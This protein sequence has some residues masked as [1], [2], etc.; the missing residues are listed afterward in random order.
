M[1][2]GGPGHRPPPHRSY[3]A[4][5]R[6]RRCPGRWPARRWR[7][8]LRVRL[9]RSPIARGP[10]PHPGGAVGRGDDGR[11][12]R[13]VLLTLAGRAVRPLPTGRR[14]AARSGAASRRLHLP[15][16]GSGPARGPR[17]A[18][19]VRLGRGLP[20]SLRPVPGGPGPAGP[21]RR[22]S[23]DRPLGRPRVRRRR[24][25]GRG[26]RDRAG[27]VA[28][29]TRCGDRGPPDVAAAAGHRQRPDRRRPVA[30]SRSGRR[31]DRRRLPHGRPGAAAQ[32]R[33]RPGPATTGAETAPDRGAVGVARRLPGR[34]DRVPPAAGHLGP[35]LPPAAAGPALPGMAAAALGGQPRPVGRLP[36]GAAATARSVAPP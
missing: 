32:G 29:A 1:V 3:R 26:P 33:R 36:L 16:R 14:A 15:G 23:L 2:A 25:A 19:G 27:S 5:R 24:L 20:G 11:D 34:G 13:G 10:D 30:P 12:R 8:P 4:P 31:P 7:V 28:P 18:P 21:P 6:V 22:G 35:V 9:R 17:A